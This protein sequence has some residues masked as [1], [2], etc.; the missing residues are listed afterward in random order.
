MSSDGGQTLLG[1]PV[2]LGKIPWLKAWKIKSGLFLDIK[3]GGKDA[4]GCKSLL[5]KAGELSLSC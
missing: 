4:D 1:E 5:I 2:F 3:A